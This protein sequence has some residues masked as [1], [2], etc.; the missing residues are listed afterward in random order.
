[1]KRIPIETAAPYEVVA[2]EN[3][4]KDAGAYMRAAGVAAR[5]AFIVSDDVVLPL[6]GGAV[7]GVVILSHE[8]T[9]GL[10]A[11]AENESFLGQ[12]SGGAGPFSVVKSAPAAEN[13]V[14]ALTGAT[15]TSTAVTEAVNQAVSYFEQGKEGA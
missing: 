11:N 5:K 12:Y 14:E 1:M 9:P 10:G 2:G 8:E 13:Q 6:Y 15:V 3:I 4:L 7:R